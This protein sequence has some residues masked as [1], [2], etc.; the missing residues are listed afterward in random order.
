MT[1]DRN[2]PIFSRLWLF[3]SR[4]MDDGGMRERR[5][6]LLAGLSGYVLEVGA[7]TGANFALYPRDV[8]RVAAVEPELHLRRTAQAA[9]ERAPVVVTVVSGTAESLPFPD[10]TFDAVVYSLVLCSV[11]SQARALQEARRVLKPGGEVRFL[12]HVRSLNL[13]LGRGQ[14]LL[15]A[16]VYPL[17][18]GGCHL[19][20]DTGSALRSAGFDM[21]RIVRFRWPSGCALVPTSQHI[22]GTAVRV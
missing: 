20:R 2:R 15:D 3:L 13:W 17:V 10:A 11:S 16:T 4:L 5:R 19:G 6:E 14:D 12:E 9:A 22:V 7:G 21:Q 18:S 1:A 8:I